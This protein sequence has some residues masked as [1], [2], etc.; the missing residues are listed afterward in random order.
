MVY[1]PFERRGSQASY[2]SDKLPQRHQPPQDQLHRS[3]TL[4]R[5]DTARRPYPTDR[6][7]NIERKGS[8]DEV[9]R[10]HDQYDRSREA[11]R[12]RETAFPARADVYSSKADVYSSKVRFV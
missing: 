4:G 12:M 2:H 8:R 5:F 3:A 11:E 1:D 6:T 10:S 7:S 9:R